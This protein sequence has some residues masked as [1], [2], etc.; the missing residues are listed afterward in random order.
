[1]AH[2][3]PMYDVQ[4]CAQAHTERG[5]RYVLRSHGALRRSALLALLPGVLVVCALHVDVAR[6]VNAV[7]PTTTLSSYSA[8]TPGVTYTFSG[9][10]VA[11]GEMAT[12]AIVTFPAGTN[13][14][15]ATLLSP[16]GTLSVSG[17]SVTITFAPNIMKGNRVVIGLGGIT[18]PS[19]QGTY[20]VGDATHPGTITFQTAN[21]NNNQA[22]APQYI[23]SPSYTIGPP[24][25]LTMT[26]TTP[27]AGQTVDFGAIDPGVT[28]PAKQVTVT[29]SSSAAYTISRAYG[30]SAAQLGL[31]VNGTATGTKTAG[32]NQVWTDD[33]QLTP[34][35]TTDPEVPLTA[36]VVYTVTQ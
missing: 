8:G 25:Y 14:A 32:D 20:A 28:T 17:Q 36:T 3:L 24:P 12:G 29:V 19:A 1:M 9:Y 22:R 30:G 4:G 35:W 7:T 31:T 33:Y 26:I 11:N 27:D 15:G 23:T 21:P 5:K 10:T 18:N 2:S 16:T 34:L 13:V 6:A